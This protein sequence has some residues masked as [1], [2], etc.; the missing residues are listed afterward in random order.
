M[1]STATRKR[2][3]ASY[4]GAGIIPGEG[5]GVTPLGPT[6]AIFTAGANSG[7]LIAL[8]TGL[9]D[10]E[11]ITGVM[12][13][14][15]RLAIAGSGTQLVVGLSA[16][17][18][19]NI[20][21]VLTS[22][23]GRTLN[24]AITVEASVL[25]AMNAVRIFGPGHNGAVPTTSASGGT[26][27]WTTTLVNESGA[28]IETADVIFSGRYLSQTGVGNVGNDVPTT[29]NL[30]YNSV[31]TPLPTVT[32]L[33]EVETVSAEVAMPTPIP[34]GASFTV[35]GTM[36]LTAGQK[37]QANAGVCMVRSKRA[38]SSMKAING[39]GLGDSI[40]TNNSGLWHSAA[41]GR[42]PMIQISIIGS[43]ASSYATAENHAF[44]KNLAVLAGVNHVFCNFWVNDATA[45]R[46]NAQVMADLDAIA[47]DM[48]AGTKW[49]QATS[50]P[51]SNAVTVAATS[52]AISGGL[53]TVT[54]PDASMF[55]LAVRYTFTGFTP[56]L[57]VRPPLSIDTGA[58]TVTFAAGDLADGA[59]SVLGTIGIGSGAQS[60][61]FQTPR[62]A[63]GSNTQRNA[64]NNDVV[65]AG[66]FS[67]GFLELANACEVTPDAGIWATGGEKPKL[68]SY[69]DV[70][71][72][73]LTST[74]RFNCTTSGQPAN[75]G[76]GGVALWLTG[77]NARRFQ[78]LSSN[79]SPT[80][81]S[82][83]AAPPSPFAIGDTLRIF[84]AS[85]SASDD[86][87]HP[88]VA[89]GG[90]GGQQLIVDAAMADFDAR[91]AA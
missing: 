33:N 82:L 66:H 39:L 45:S 62:T 69:V 4:I 71:I 38:R 36:T 1:V 23:T 84:P 31:T 12:P 34:A 42:F 80:D 14:D 46:T 19:G 61:K 16:S 79:N 56:A 89:S 57:G 70:T 3:V 13:N 49:V 41:A 58:N 9:Q 78:N 65:R 30:T 87:Q 48:P 11:T 7:S 90:Y 17:S 73:G 6:N 63:A 75:S 29:V 24:M 20:A 40:V 64:W 52:A 91:L 43:R 55:D 35:S 8:I 15:G 5:G 18:A 37:Y 50:T 68:L 86:R 60:R 76:A 53:L 2:R 67:G 47:S 54:V 72:T 32:V 59:V 10:G 85:Q 81:Y 83:S 74:T 77:P 28:P 44:Q 51:Y 26:V 25:V 21:A 88:R 27:N 22:S